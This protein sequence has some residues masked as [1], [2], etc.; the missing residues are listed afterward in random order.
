[1]ATEI[2]LWEIVEGKLI[3]SEVSMVDAGRTEVNDLERWIKDNPEILGGD[4]LIIGEQIMTK[5]GPLDFLGIDQSG[6][7]IIIELKRD[8]LHRE[9]LSQAIDYASDISS[10]D[11]ERLNEECERYTGKKISEC[12]IEN[13]DLDEESIEDISINNFQKI[14]LVG[15]SVDESLERMIGW[16]SNNYDMGINVLVL[17]YTKTKMGDEI[18]AR[19]TIIPEEIE[20]EKSQ[21]HQR[22]IYA[23]RHF[24]RK[25]FWGQLLE[26]INKKSNFFSR[27]SPGIY[28]WVGT[29]AGKTGIGYN[30]VIFN[31]ESGCE[32][33]LD[34]GKEY[35]N[36]NINKKRFDQLVSFKEEI[37]NKLGFSLNWERLD[38]KRASRIG[39]R[40]EDGGLR[41]KEKWGALQDRMI[42]RMIKIESIFKDHIRNLQ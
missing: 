24:L 27:I 10:W 4:I 34:R 31:N 15:T 41:D 2:K 22:K 16:L 5:R 23:E 6:N 1:M 11:L 30:F 29:G 20:Q 36:P 18:I 17:K 40:F 9:V 3:P 14:L 42:E 7:L 28:H 13:F 12:L 32:I 38:N 26:K 33:Y 25:E 21:R 39:V 35:V 19:T 37:E 8:K